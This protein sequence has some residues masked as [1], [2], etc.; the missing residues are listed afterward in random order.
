MKK[1][2]VMCMSTAAIFAAISVPAIVASAETYADSAQMVQDWHKNGYPSYVCGVW[3]ET[4]QTNHFVIGIVSGEEGENGKKEILSQLSDP[5]SIS[6]VTQ[7]FSHDMLGAILMKIDAYMREHNATQDVY[8]WGIDEKENC[9][10]VGCNLDTPSESL[11]KM[12]SYFTHYDGSVIFEQDSASETSQMNESR[13]VPDYPTDTMDGLPAEITADASSQASP[14]DPL[15]WSEES[16][17]DKD[18]T[19]CIGAIVDGQSAE[20]SPNMEIG[21]DTY[22][23]A[24]P[25]LAGTFDSGNSQNS[26]SKTVLWT[27]CGIATALLLG[28]AAV[29]FYWKRRAN[30][31][32]TNTGTVIHSGK[33]S[34]KQTENAVREHT[35]EP[36]ERLRKEIWDT[37][38]Q[39]T[40]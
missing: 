32:Q 20:G 8:R 35:P 36:P 39:K 6:F 23:T 14:D 21:A 27:A 38:K 17:A 2:Y 29:L 25:V 34:R 22:G 5:D 12:M 33:M 7:K 37:M 26:T 24:P 31:M 10:R 11:K 16:G 1:R 15:K 3:S 13:F 18:N 40:K 9:I 19:Y 30:A 28:S 4:D